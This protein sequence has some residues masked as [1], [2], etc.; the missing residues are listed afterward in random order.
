[1]AATAE[2]KSDRQLRLGLPADGAARDAFL[3]ALRS[4]GILAYKRN[5]GSP[6][7]Y[8][9][10]KSLAVGMVAEL[11]P[12][13]LPPQVV[14][15]FM[16]GGSIEIAL[17]R[18]L[19]LRVHAYDIF[20][21]LVNYWRAQ[22]SDAEK[23]YR[24][25]KQFEPTRPTFAAVKERLQAHWPGGEPPYY[26]AQGKTF[27]GMYR[28]RNFPIHHHGFRHDK[29]RD[30]LLA[31]DGGFIL[32]YN[33]CEVIRDWYGDCRIAAPQWQYTFGQ[34]DTRIGHNRRQSNNG[35]HIKKSHELLIW[36]YADRN[37]ADQGAKE[38]AA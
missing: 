35:S 16:G 22:M 30:L 27:V 37:S 3:H 12:S 13:P 23:L 31:H 25:L 10:G 6:L 32:S 34:G 4:R 29:L 33:D 21:I 19:G 8:A 38:K 5:P 7:R 26:L 1:M 24:L 18:E 11:L 17:A 36:K 9:G 15:P 2:Q 20:D 28:R 14:S